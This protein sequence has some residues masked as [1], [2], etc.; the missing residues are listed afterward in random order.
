MPVS[1]ADAARPSRRPRRRFRTVLAFCAAAALAAATVSG[2]ADFSKQDNDRNAG[3]FSKN[4]ESFEIKRPPRTPPPPPP[5][6]PSPPPG[7]CVDPDPNVITTCLDSTAAVTPADASGSFT[8][9]AER[10]TGKI[11]RAQRFSEHK[12]LMTIPGVDASGDGGL[13]DFAQSPTY[14]Q[15]KLWYAYVTTPTDNRIVRIAHGDVPKPILTG[16]PKGR[17]GNLGSMFFR[18]TGELIVATGDAGNP[19]AANDPNSLAGKV[20]LVTE[21]SSGRNPR[22]KILASGVG[23]NP[24]LCPSN[25]TIF[26]ADGTANADRLSQVSG[27]SLRTVWSWPDKPGLGGCAVVEDM[28]AVSTQRT[29]R[30]ETLRAPTPEKPSIDKPTVVLEKQ[31]GAIGRMR[32][33]GNGLIQF[34][35]VNKQYGSKVVTQDERVVRFLVP[36]G[37]GGGEDRM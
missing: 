23:S 12:V 29:Q 30:I 10:T 21:F 13:I 35:T 16:I 9:V 22:P 2:C 15:D 1:A 7:P 31:Y 14:N 25:S 6:L 11:I 17:T 4:N 3:P 19:A 24:A 20:L 34:A 32:P 28:I 5:G 36:G 33:V 8:V 27:R 26:V 37:A 18:S